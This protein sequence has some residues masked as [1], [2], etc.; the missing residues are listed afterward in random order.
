MQRR[1]AARTMRD[2]ACVALLAMS[3]TGF[4]Q[5]GTASAQGSQ[6]PAQTEGRGG[7]GRRNGRGV[8]GSVTSTSAAGIMLKTDAGEVWT[9][10]TTDN[11]RLMKDQQPVKVADVKSGDEVMAYGIPDAPA[12]QLHAMMVMVVDAAVAA[13]ARENLGKTYIV[14]RIT[15]IDETKLTV[16]RPDHIAQTITVDETTSF[17][18]GGRLNL[19]GLGFVPGIGGGGGGGR[20]AR[21]S[22]GPRGDENGESIT[23]AD[24]KVGDQVAG[25]G[26]M[27]GG[28]FVPAELRVI[29]RP[30]RPEGGNGGAAP[31]QP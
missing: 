29:V 6:A 9:V 30:P 23:L 7:E 27:K 8:R 21:N 13:K 31:P 26:A 11:T 28:S 14:G 10:Q 18:R 24:I 19:E 3:C 20:G 4:A 1:A 15:A 2:A 22:N 16:Q 25:T 17:H 5:G 12:H